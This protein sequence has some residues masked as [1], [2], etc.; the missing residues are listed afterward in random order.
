M[1]GLPVLNGFSIINVN[2]EKTIVVAECENHKSC[3]ST[4]ERRLATERIGVPEFWKV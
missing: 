1:N 3:F 2:D 4:N